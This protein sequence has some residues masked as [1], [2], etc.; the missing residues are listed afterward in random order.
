MTVSTSLDCRGDV[1]ISSTPPPPL[2]LTSDLDANLVPAKGATLEVSSVGVLA[3]AGTFRPY[4]NVRRVPP[5]N[6]E[7][8][9]DVSCAFTL[10]TSVSSE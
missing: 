3:T 2:L 9:E 1:L 4:V 10:D 7:P 5:E 6:A 8:G